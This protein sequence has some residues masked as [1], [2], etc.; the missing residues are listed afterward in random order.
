MVRLKRKWRGRGKKKKGG[1]GE[2]AEKITAG[3]HQHGNNSKKRPTRKVEGIEANRVNHEDS[4]TGDV[5]GGMKYTG[6]GA[7]GEKGVVGSTGS[8]RGTNPG[9]NGRGRTGQLGGG[10]G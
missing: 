10:I 2:E 8:R 9:K 3:G 4:L 5:R 1:K 7:V 6:W